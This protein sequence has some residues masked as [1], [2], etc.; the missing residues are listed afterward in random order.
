MKKILLLLALLALTTATS[1]AQKKE[2]ERVQNAGTVM[3]EILNIP[4]DIPQ[5]VLNKAECVIVLPSVVKFA[6][7]IGGSY[8]RGVMTCR[9]GENFKGPWS[10]PTMIAVEG[11]SFG[12]Q[13]GG[14]ATDFILL[15]MN[16]RGANGILTGKVKLGADAAAAAGPKGRDAAAATD[17]TMRA[18]ILSYSRARGLFAGVSLEGSTLRPDNGANKSLYG[19]EIPAKDIVL[20][21]AVQPPV[22]AKLLLATLNQ[23]SPKNISG[24]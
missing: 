22:S 3:K 19:K 15:V 16:D 17:V 11:G 4:D 21:G 5:S 6:I 18:E 13:L 12:L 2:Q 24:R 14:Q 1:S 9:G 20:K 7:G 10:S 23:K 8:G